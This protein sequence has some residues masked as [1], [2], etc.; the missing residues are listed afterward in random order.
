VDA[1]LELALPSLNCLTFC[2]DTSQRKLN[3]P[4]RPDTEAKEVCEHLPLHSTAVSLPPSRRGKMHRQETQGKETAA[5]D[6]DPKNGMLTESSPVSCDK[7]HGHDRA[8]VEHHEHT[9]DG[10]RSHPNEHRDGTTPERADSPGRYTQ[11]PELLEGWVG[12]A[13]GRDNNM[14]TFTGQPGIKGRS[15]SIRMMLLCA[16]HF[17]ITF[18]WYGFVHRVHLVHL[19]RAPWGHRLLLHFKTPSHV[20]LEGCAC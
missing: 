11:G 3:H 14:S 2:L 15:E 12:P 1:R 19:A 13:L 16:I 5:G 18:T 9:Q 20:T 8:R 4:D 10:Q 17:G 6:D 7:T